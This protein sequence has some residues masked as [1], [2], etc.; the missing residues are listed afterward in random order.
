MAKVDFEI[1][2]STSHNL[3]VIKV[4]FQESP[5]LKYH[6]FNHIFEYCFSLVHH[7]D[8]VSCFSVG[9]TLV[10]VQLTG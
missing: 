6:K 7:L 1:T 9:I 10:N 4:V 5:S 2:D 3:G 8:D